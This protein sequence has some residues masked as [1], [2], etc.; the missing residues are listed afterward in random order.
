MNDRELIQKAA[1]LARSAPENWK[2]FLGALSTYT[3]NQ[4]SNCVSSPLEALPQ[5]QGRAQATVALLRLLR[6]C[7]KTADQIEGKR[8]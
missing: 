6:E 8:K 5:N 2:E 7:L 4:I 3:D 1:A